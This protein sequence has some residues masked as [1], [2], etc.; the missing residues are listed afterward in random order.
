MIRSLYAVTPSTVCFMHPGART[1]VFW[2]LDPE[3]ASEVLASG[4]AALEKEAWINRILVERG[5]C[6]YNIGTVEEPEAIASVLYCAPVD[7]S[8]VVQL[9]TGPVSPDA[10]LLSSLFIDDRFRGLALE[11]VLVT[12]VII[13]L[14]RRGV[15]A[16]EAF[17]VRDRAPDSAEDDPSREIAEHASEIGLLSFDILSAA[18]FEVVADHDLL[19]RLRLSLSGC[20]RKQIAAAA[21]LPL[22]MIPG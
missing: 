11:S 20:D 3:T 9:P 21:D 6:G 10:V 18:G 16:V 14:T 22:V 4:A 19:P 13:E 15:R 2:E 12:A 17:A 8:G 5:G 7:A 1:S